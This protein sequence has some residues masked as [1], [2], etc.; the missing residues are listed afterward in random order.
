M[1]MIGQKILIVEDDD[2]LRP[3]L[4]R[5]LNAAGWRTVTYASAEALLADAAAGDAACVVCDLKL[6]AMSGFDLLTAWREQGGRPLV[7][8]ITAYDAPGLSEEAARRGAA[9]HLVK[10]FRGTALLEA[11]DTAIKSARLG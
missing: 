6:P 8:L 5:L 11:I 1:G 4:E 9:A 7:I 2:S 3:A 10:P